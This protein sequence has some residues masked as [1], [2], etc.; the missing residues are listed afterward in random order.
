MVY[1]FNLFGTRCKIILLF[2]LLASGELCAQQLLRGLVMTEDSS[3]LLENTVIKNINSGRG[4]LTN[5]SGFYKIMA[6]PGDMIEFSKTGYTSRKITYKGET[7]LNV[8]LRESE[9]ALEEI[10]VSASRGNQAL[11][12]TSV[13]MESIKPYLIENK[14]PSTL[15]NTIDQIPGVQSV[16]G[17]V[18]I[19]GGSGWSYGA[20]SRV[21]VMLDGMPMLSGDAGQVMWSFLPVENIENLEVIKGA[22]SV[23]YG[24]SALNGVIN[25]KTAMPGAKPLTKISTFYGFYGK[26]SEEG[27][28]WNPNQILSQ[29]G[30]RA[31]HSQR[32]DKNNALTITLNGFKDDGYRMS[33]ADERMRMGFQY[34]REWPSVKNPKTKA[35]SGLNGNLQKGRSSS[36]LLW[37]NDKLAYTSLDSNYT[38]NGTLRI[39]LDPYFTLNKRGWKHLMQGR[40][41]RIEN[42]VEDNAAGSSNQSNYSNNWFGEYQISKTFFKIIHA[43]AGTSGNISISESPLYQGH[44]KASNKALYLQANTLLKGWAFDAGIRYEN[45]KLNNYKESRPVLRTGVSR[46]L[47]KFTFARASF[48]QGYRFPTIAESYILTSVGPIKIYPNQ[49]LKSENGWNA[50]LGLKQGMRFGKMDAILDVAGFWMEYERMMEFTFAQWEK[51]SIQNPLPVGFKSVNVSY[52]KIRGVDLSFAGTRKWKLSELKWLMGYTYSHAISTQPRAVFYTD[53]LNN[54]LTFANTSSDT[55]GYFLKYRPKH[56]ARLDLQYSLRQWELGVSMRY[57]SYLQNIDKAFVSF[58]I[59]FVAPGVQTVRDEGKKGDHVFDLRFGKSFQKFKVLL[60]V[61]NVLNRKY[62]TRPYDMR[63]PRSYMLQFTIQL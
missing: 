20:G 50:E 49:Q 18:V 46:A 26:P 52:A 44:Q 13:S 11:K 23:L 4:S 48:G 15:E 30:I 24:S 12:N 47:S 8:T 5:D 9:N 59:A 54:K 33:D 17:Q 29:Y 56:L 3:V 41:L 2:I 36:F 14:N 51:P 10:V 62:M 16:N 42:K 39:N 61:N 19:R 6:T 57:N 31:F 37:E 35:R 40:Y 43:V 25:I 1:N 38:K 63:P 28:R 34:F 27:L 55:S 22:A 32:L 7:V 45:Y 58:P 53:S 60:L 21:M